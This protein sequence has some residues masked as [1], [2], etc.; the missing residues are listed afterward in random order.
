MK[1]KPD[2]LFEDLMNKCAIKEANVPGEE[3]RGPRR[4]RDVK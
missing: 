2:Q 3:R 4:K 1:C